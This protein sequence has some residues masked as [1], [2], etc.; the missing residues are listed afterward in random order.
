M[1]LIKRAVAT[2][3]R[4]STPAGAEWGNSVPPTNGSLGGGVA[5]TVVSEKT[6]LQV[7]AVYGSV[8]VLADGL[9]TLPIDL[10]NSN[11]P[12]VRRKLPLT[13]LLLDPYEEISQIDWL[14]QYTISMALRGNFYGHIIERDANLY[15]SQIKPIHPDNA[16]VRRLPDGT[17]EYRYNG[18]V[19]PIDEVFHV[20][21][22]SVP[23]SLVGLNPIEYLR[24]A[25]GLA[26]AEDLYGASYFQ[27]SANPGGV[28]EIEDDLDDD[29]TLAMA[30]TW[31]QA[32]QGI[33]N[34]N[35]PAVLTGGATFKPI[36]ITPEDSQFLESRQFSAST[37]S[38]MIFRVPPHMIGIV[39]RST[40]WGTGI[41]QQERGFV[42]NTLGGYLRRL[43]KALT[44]LHPPS[45]YVRF[46][47]NERLRGDR[48]QRYQ[49]YGIGV[50]AGFL[51]PD[52]ARAE[53]FMAPLP[54]GLGQTFMVPINSQ[55]I[56][57]AVQATMEPARQS[58]PPSGDAG[59]QQGGGQR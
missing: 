52:D 38:G 31:M 45:Q 26:R 42:T 24:N 58:P 22:L 14:T 29:E 48:L 43:E 36:T 55:T 28:I 27:N 33:G 19:V 44:S 32:H 40:S 8:G 59:D 17:L 35:L 18:Q 56:E 21:Y 4:R 37:I 51:C 49:A 15:A 2:L 5:G 47:L 39:D 16:R 34:A 10:Y 12:A 23:Q 20:K 6:A 30:K 13:S 53:E 7:T 25:F 46:D 54:D 3:E 11:D 41:E 57:A 9:A 1:A 50:A